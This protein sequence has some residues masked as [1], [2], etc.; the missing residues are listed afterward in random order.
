MTK[1]GYIDNKH[2]VLVIDDDD[3][4][5]NPAYRFNILASHRWLI[6]QM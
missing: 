4:T 5:N 1:N 3:I 2:P 6:A